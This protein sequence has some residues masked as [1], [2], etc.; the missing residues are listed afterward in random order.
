MGPG[1]PEFSSNSNQTHLNKLIKVF[2]V[3]RATGFFRV[4][5]TLPIFLQYM[6][7]SFRETGYALS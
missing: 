4:G 2:R 1:V 5:A 6:Y 3:T 7:L